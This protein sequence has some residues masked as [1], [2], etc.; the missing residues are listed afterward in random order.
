MFKNLAI[1][2]VLLGILSSC[3]RCRDYK[4]RITDKSGNVVH[5]NYLSIESHAVGY[6]KG[7]TINIDEHTSGIVYHI[8]ADTLR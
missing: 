8:I 7:D 2:V 3:G 5:S 1:V 6:V 4:V